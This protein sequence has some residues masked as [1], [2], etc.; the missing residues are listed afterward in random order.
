MVP[1]IMASLA[2]WSEDRSPRTIK[3]QAASTRM[4]LFQRPLLTAGAMERPIAFPTT[5]APVMLA[6]VRSYVNRHAVAQVGKVSV[7]TNNDDGWRTASDLQKQG[8]EV[9]AGW[10]VRNASAFVSLNGVETIHGAHIVDTATQVTKIDQT[11]QW[12]DYSN[13]LPCGCRRLEP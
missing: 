4:Y 13:R 9:V 2:L 11:E 5:N 7:F 3:R 8:V 6:G 10:D 1:M 12:Q